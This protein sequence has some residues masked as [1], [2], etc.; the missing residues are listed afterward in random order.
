MRNPLLGIPSR[1]AGAGFEGWPGL[2][3]RKVEENRFST[4]WAVGREKSAALRLRKAQ[5]QAEG[6]EVGQ[7]LLISYQ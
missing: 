7:K 6:V 4:G 1:W 3:G 5:L 2:S